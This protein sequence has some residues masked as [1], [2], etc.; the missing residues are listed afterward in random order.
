MYAALKALYQIIQD[1]SIFNEPDINIELAVYPSTAISI[2]EVSLE[3]MQSV[4][5]CSIIIPA[6]NNQ[7]QC[8]F[9]CAIRLGLLV[10][11]KPQ[12]FLQIHD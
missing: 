7:I 8:Q 2:H 12:S 9:I 6:F 4:A 11:D 5:A 10:D 1:G 3:L